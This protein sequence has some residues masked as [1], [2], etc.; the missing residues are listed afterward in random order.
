MKKFKLRFFL[1]YQ[2]CFWDACCDNDDCELVN[3]RE[4]LSESTRMELENFLVEYNASYDYGLPPYKE[5]DVEYCKHFNKELKRVTDLVFPEL[6][7]QFIICHEQFE[8]I[9][10]DA[11]LK[12]HQA[13]PSKAMQQRRLLYN[14]D[15]ETYL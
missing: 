4:I 5:H 11:L 7:E 15:E 9:E 8:L 14:V 1:D 6:A 12:K 2:E 3:P 10:D 13:N